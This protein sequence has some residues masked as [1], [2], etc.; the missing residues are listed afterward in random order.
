MMFFIS[1][2][3]KRNC[4]WSQGKTTTKYVNHNDI[5]YSKK[6]LSRNKSAESEITLKSTQGVR[7]LLMLQRQLN[8]KSCRAQDRVILEPTR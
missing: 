8:H 3:L 1:L 2:I 4:D 6:I 5:I 7:E